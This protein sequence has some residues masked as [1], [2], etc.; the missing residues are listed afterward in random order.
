M[1]AAASIAGLNLACLLITSVLV[2]RRFLAEELLDWL[3]SA[4]L[5][6]MLAGGSMALALRY[7]MPEVHGRIGAF[8]QLGLAGVAIG[9]VVFACLPRPRQRVYAMITRRP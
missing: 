3:V 4:V 8:L 7:V 1:G 2:L 9:S 6:P 5:V